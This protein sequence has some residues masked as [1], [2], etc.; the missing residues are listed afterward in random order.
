MSANIV[1]PSA[2][3]VSDPEPASDAA[4]AYIA[5]RSLHYA[6]ELSVWPGSNESVGT[7]THGPLVVASRPS[8]LGV[9]QRRNYVVWK[10]EMGGKDMLHLWVRDEEEDAVGD[11]W[12]VRPEG[13]GNETIS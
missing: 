11:I 4:F 9:V 5:R 7:V 10:G 6:G 1:A 13:W 8:W 12:W 3:N 2:L